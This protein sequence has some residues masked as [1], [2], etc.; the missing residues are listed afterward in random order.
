MSDREHARGHVSPASRVNQS[1]RGRESRTWASRRRMG[2]EVS[3]LGDSCKIIARVL[4][5]SESAQHTHTH[6]S[7]GGN[8][9]WWC[10]SGLCQSLYVSVY[11]QSV[12]DKLWFLHV[13][14]FARLQSAYI[15]AKLKKRTYTYESLQFPVEINTRG[16]KNPTTFI[17]FNTKYDLQVHRF[18][19]INPNF[20]II[21]WGTLCYE[22]KTIWTCCEIW[23]LMHLKVSITYPAS[24]AWGF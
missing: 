17:P 10:G 18:R 19:L 14:G 3:P 21:T 2:A 12:K 9:F 15:S 23:K 7:Y 1:T 5:L 22:F 24:Y 6:T 13:L 20:C 8:L 11:H 4:F 16:S